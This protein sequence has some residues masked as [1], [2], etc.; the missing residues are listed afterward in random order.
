MFHEF[1]F[2][3]IETVR[4]P[5]SLGRILQRKAMLRWSSIHLR[6]CQATLQFPMPDVATFKVWRC[7]QEFYKL[8]SLN[9][10]KPF[11]KKNMAHDHLSLHNVKLRWNPC[12][13]ELQMPA[14]TARPWGLPATNDK[15]H[16]SVVANLWILGHF[17]PFHRLPKLLG[18]YVL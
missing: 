8:R 1:H 9:A 6:C 5:S 14:H 2:P 12:D 4:I 17:H 7:V 18:R 11:V 16:W 10:D 3:S 15:L 13:S